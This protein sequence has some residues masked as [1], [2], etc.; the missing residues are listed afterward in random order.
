MFWKC[1]YHQPSPGGGDLGYGRVQSKCLISLSRWGQ[2]TTKVKRLS[3]LEGWHISK[4]EA[5][6][7]FAGQIKALLTCDWKAILSQD[8][9]RF[10]TM[11]NSLPFWSKQT[12]RRWRS[13]CS[14][15]LWSFLSFKTT[16][17][18]FLIKCWCKVAVYLRERM[19]KIKKSSFQC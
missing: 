11:L 4:Q 10:Y 9:K 19:D 6:L 1:T 7:K 3:L 14:C 17:S 5:T 8:K 13:L 18:D 12:A 16:W 15:V 2:R